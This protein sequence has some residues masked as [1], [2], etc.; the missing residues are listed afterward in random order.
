MNKITIV[1]ISTLVATACSSTTSEEKTD[2]QY[3]DLSSAENRELVDDYWVVSK[4]TAPQY[5]V[6][7]ARDG[8]SGCV[9]LAVGIG[10]DGRVQ[11]YRTLSSYPQG[12]FDDYAAA[13]LGEWKWEATEANADRTPVIAH[14]SLS[15]TIEKDQED[16]DFIANCTTE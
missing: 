5:P 1:F 12:V 14:K 15:F 16:P 8:V 2:T 10:S 11:G 13:A 6:S 3:L 9:E 4:R 7:A